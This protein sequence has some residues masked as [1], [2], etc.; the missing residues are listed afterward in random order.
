MW[1]ILLVLLLALHGLVHIL[2]AV[3]YWDI[4]TVDALRAPEI[5][6]VLVRILGALWLVPALGFISLA[7]GIWRSTEWRRN[8]VVAMAMLSMILGIV[9][10]PDAWAGMLIDSILLAWLMVRS[11]LQESAHLAARG[12]RQYGEMS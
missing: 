10:W 3:A 4:A 7:Y 8:V 11:P 9:A 2:G 1:R 5:A 6:P 12:M